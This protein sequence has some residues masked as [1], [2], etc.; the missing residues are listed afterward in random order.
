MVRDQIEKGQINGPRLIP[1]GN[2]LFLASSTPDAVRAEIRKLAQLGVR[3]T[4]EML[5]TPVPGADAQRAGD[6]G[7]GP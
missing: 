6:P 4:G 1:S 3:Y 7:S 5:L 2:T